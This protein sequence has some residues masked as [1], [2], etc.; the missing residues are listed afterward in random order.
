LWTT[1]QRGRVAEELARL[2]EKAFE[3]FPCYTQSKGSPETKPASAVSLPWKES[4]SPTPPWTER[5][6]ERVVV[7]DSVEEAVRVLRHEVE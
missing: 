1:V 6:A 5:R 3:V 2:S 4:G 7:S